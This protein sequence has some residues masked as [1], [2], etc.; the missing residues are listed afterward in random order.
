MNQESVFPFLPF[1]FSFVYCS[2][3]E[4]DDSGVVVM[5]VIVPY[6]GG[7]LLIVAGHR[8]SKGRALNR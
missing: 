8:K 2:E 3:E 1:H 5:A 7:G 6:G 4:S